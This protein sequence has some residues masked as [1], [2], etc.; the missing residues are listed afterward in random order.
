MIFELMAAEVLFELVSRISRLVQADGRASGLPAAQLEALTYVA[1]ANRY[2]D[3]PS[4]V[5]EYFGTSRGTTSQ[6]IRALERAGL[7]VRRA[8]RDDGRVFHLALTE[9]GRRLLRRFV[10]PPTLQAATASLGPAG[11]AE[12]EEALRGLLRAMTRANRGRAFGVCRTCKHFRR[13]RQRSYRCGLT[14]EP[15]SESDS[16]LLCREH[17]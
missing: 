8:D 17:A 14:G 12:V 2:S 9:P 1:I 13:E 10:P 7:L 3:T 5:A 6:T 4:A 16:T 15:L 11:T